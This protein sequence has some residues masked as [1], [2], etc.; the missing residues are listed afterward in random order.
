[1]LAALY[2]IPRSADEWGFFFNHN[3]AEHTLIARAL[4]AQH[5][6][7]LPEYILFPVPPEYLKSWFSNHQDLHN[8]IDAAL[9]IQT[10]NLSEFDLKDEKALESF[11]QFHF[12]EHYLANQG[13]KI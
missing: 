6:I 4:K 11:F 9:G 3:N 7:I 2:N 12:N 1:M 5:N 8:R 10:N 13:L